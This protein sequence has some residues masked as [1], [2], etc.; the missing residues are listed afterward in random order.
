MRL[1]KPDGTT[2]DAVP[3]PGAGEPVWRL[4]RD[5]VALIEAGGQTPVVIE[6]PGASIVLEPGDDYVIV[7]RERY[8][9]MATELAVFKDFEKRA[10]DWTR[11]RHRRREERGSRP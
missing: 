9:R 5:Q 2:T 8:T 7:A 1:L 11:R 6:T 4:S 10:M 3:E